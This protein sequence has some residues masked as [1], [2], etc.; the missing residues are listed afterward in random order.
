MSKP[1]VTLKPSEQTIVTAAAQ[2][3]AG[4]LAAGRVSDESE[5]PTYLK[6]ALQQAIQLARQTDEI[7]QADGEFD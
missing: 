1:Y 2:I 6:K 3:Y 7:V 4:Y 5:E